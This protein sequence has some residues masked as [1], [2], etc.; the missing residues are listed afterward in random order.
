MGQKIFANYIVEVPTLVLLRHPCV[1]AGSNS[2]TCLFTVSLWGNVCPA[3]ARRATFLLTIP[4]LAPDLLSHGEAPQ[5]DHVGLHTFPTKQL[6]NKAIAVNSTT[7][8]VICIVLNKQ[9]WS[10]KCVPGSSIALEG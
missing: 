8:N 9:H 10:H 6:H 2:A 7:P 5:V 4:T 1:Q 3:R